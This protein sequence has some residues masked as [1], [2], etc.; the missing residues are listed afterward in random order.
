MTDSDKNDQ[1]KPETFLNVEKNGESYIETDTKGERHTYVKVRQ[2]PVVSIESLNTH[3][4]VALQS[5]DVITTIR[6]RTRQKIRAIGA[7]GNYPIFRVDLVEGD[8]PGQATITNRYRIG[9]QSLYSELVICVSRNAALALSETLRRSK[10][11]P[12]ISAEFKE[13]TFLGEKPD[14]FGET[15]L[16][17][18]LEEQEKVAEREI[19]VRYNLE[20]VNLT[21]S[22]EHA[23]GFIALRGEADESAQTVRAG[24]AGEVRVVHSDESIR[25]LHAPI[26]EDLATIRV[27]VERLGYILIAVAVLIALY[28]YHAW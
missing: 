4:A 9:G 22:P 6:G 28:V 23:A 10:T 14:F 15:L 21:V 19:T 12:V 8:R 26:R 2:R 18:W 1:N 25:A 16:L 27:A 17:P 7:S 24:I 3:R 13:G 20:V 5:G 11:A